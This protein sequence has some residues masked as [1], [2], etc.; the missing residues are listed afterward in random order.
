MFLVHLGEISTEVLLHNLTS[1]NKET[2]SF[3]ALRL[4]FPQGFAVAAHVE[5]T[6]FETAEEQLRAR[7]SF[8]NRLAAART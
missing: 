3:D 4:A 8:Q 7:E 2:P 6:I 5:L 1:V